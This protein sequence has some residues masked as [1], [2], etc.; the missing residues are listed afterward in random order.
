MYDFRERKRPTEQQIQSRTA[1]GQLP[2]RAARSG[3]HSVRFSQPGV[4]IDLGGIAK[5]FAVDQRH[6][7]TARHA[8]TATRWSTRA[9]TAA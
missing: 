4:R 7:D 9:A 5:G 1:G 3:N 6:R 2:A 8:A